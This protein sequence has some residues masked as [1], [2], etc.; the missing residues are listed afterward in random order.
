MRGFC[1][2]FFRWRIKK[3]HL[4]KKTNS[5]CRGLKSSWDRWPNLPILPNGSEGLLRQ[6]K[7][8]LVVRSQWRGNSRRTAKYFST[9]PNSDCKHLVQIASVQM[10]N[11]TLYYCSFTS[12][13][14]PDY[15]CSACVIH[16]GSLFHRLWEPP[17]VQEYW[18][19]RNIIQRSSHSALKAV[20]LDASQQ[21]VKFTTQIR[22]WLF[23]W[24]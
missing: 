5:L 22:R 23:T 20:F 8:F 10:D 14:Q 24:N 12:S 1:A 9:I 17:A 21:T 3:T 7:T 16:E 2:F 18:K 4:K 15:T 6:L 11:E 19:D 13:H